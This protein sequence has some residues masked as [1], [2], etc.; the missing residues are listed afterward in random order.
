MSLLNGEG[1]RKDERNT[2]KAVSVSTKKKEEKERK[3]S[4]IE[5]FVPRYRLGSENPCRSV[6]EERTNEEVMVTHPISSLY[7]LD[8]ITLPLASRK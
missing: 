8:M 2:S 4:K 5:S 7:V 3:K 6:V 1:K